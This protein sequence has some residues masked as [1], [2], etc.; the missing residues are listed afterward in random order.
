M[1]PCWPLSFIEGCYLE[2]VLG[3][4]ASLRAQLRTTIGVSP[5]AYRRTFHIRT[6]SPLSALHHEACRPI[7]TPTAVVVGAET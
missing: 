5:S 4:A 7:T 3:T 6:P 2:G 1:R